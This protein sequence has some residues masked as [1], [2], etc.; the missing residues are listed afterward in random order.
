M[1]NYTE[2]M[3]SI[4]AAI[5]LDKNS[6][7]VNFMH[8]LVLAENKNYFEA[9][10]KYDIALSFNKK[11]LPSLM[12]KGEAFLKLED[13]NAAIEAFNSVLN[14]D[15]TCVGAYYLLGVTYTNMIEKSQENDD[16]DLLNKALE[17]L[18]KAISIEPNH[19]H[20][21]TS[22]A[23][24]YGKK[25]DYEKFKQEYKLL[26]EAFNDCSNSH[27]YDIIFKCF[28]ENLKKL[29]YNLSVEELLKES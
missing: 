27:N 22:R 23:Y 14:N 25:G 6:S 24:L 5:K 20:S 4:R 19:I 12:G 17:N 9:L 13:F 18:N 16:N 7:D 11:H 28:E 21:K 2:A 3:R 26:F 1:G 10:N 29:D 8:G 15:A